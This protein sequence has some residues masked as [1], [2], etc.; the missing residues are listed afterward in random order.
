MKALRKALRWPPVGC[1]IIS[2]LTLGALLGLRA[3]GLLQRPELILYD[4]FVRRRAVLKP[5]TETRIVLCG[6]T[7]HDLAEYGHPLDD[8]KLATLLNKIAAD[9]PA[10][11]GLDLYRDLPEPRSGA[12][13][14]QLREALLAVPK[15]VVI[16][17]VGGSQSGGREPIPAVKAPPVFAEDSESIAPNNLPV[18]YQFDGVYRRAYLYLENG[19]PHWRASFPLALVR[20]YLEGRGVADVE[21]PSTPTSAPLLRLGEVIFPRLTANAGCYSGL[22]VRDYE[23]LVDYRA[24]QDYPPVS[25]GD[26]LENRA[27]AGTFKDAIVIVG[28]M[29]DSVKDNNRTP[30]ND[31]LRGPIHHAMIVNQLLRAAFDGEPPPR[32]WPEPAKIAWIGLCTLLGGLLGLGL[33]SPWRL[34]PALA[35]L[36]AAIVFAGW[37]AL[38]HGLWIPVTTPALGAFA[39]ATFVTSLAAFIEHTDRR[40]MRALFSRHVSRD[41]LEVLWSEREQF[42]DGGRL[43]PQRVTA[44]VLFT[45]LKDYSTIAEDMDPADLMNW[46]NEYMNGIA[47]QVELHGG[48][49]NSYGGDAIMAV[50]GAPFAHTS[51][52]AIDQDA[53]RAVECALAMR[54]ELQQLNPGWAARGLPTV[55]MRV[56]I[57]TGPLVTGSIGSRQ[58]LE[59]AVLGDTTNI[60]ARLESLGKELADDAATAPCTILIGDAT[61]QRLRGRFTTRLVG[62]KRLKGKAKEVIVH[63]VLAA[64]PQPTKI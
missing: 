7:E 12:L 64:V 16:T 24:P 19:Q 43:K 45:D 59:Y 28:V 8:G 27:P 5:A 11:V 13:Y 56:G 57:F 54:R 61:W 3:R 32:W 33:R 49:I 23:I 36:L 2:L 15:M 41:V 38:L 46:I 31:R 63:S 25:F 18:D 58:R 29:A 22:S 55:A 37:Q 1:A 60:A 40:A 6:M 14:T 42:L 44:T 9:A 10:V 51:E 47:P 39:A 52:P 21:F 30:V 4:D 17:R 53:C 50:F 48:I 20:K 62:S 26:V 35:L 34:A